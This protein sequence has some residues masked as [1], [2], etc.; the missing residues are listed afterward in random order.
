MTQD[1]TIDDTS[2]K[3]TQGKGTPSYWQTACKQLAEADPVMARLIAAHH[4]DVLQGS[5]DALQTLVNAVVGQQISVHAAESIWKRFQA[6]VPE[7]TPPALAAADSD[8]LRQT[9][10]SYRKVEYVQGIAHAFLDGTLDTILDGH[11][12]NTLDDSQVR[13][14]LC[15]IRGVGPWTADMFLIFYLKRP[16]VLPT[17]DLGLVNAAVRLYGLKESKKSDNAAGCDGA[18]KLSEPDKK[19]SVIRLAEQWRPWRTVATWYIWRDLDAKPV[20]Y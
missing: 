15:S 9:G 14:K 2:R 18:G 8:A 6:L 17:G 4:N 12:L 7:M 5:G 11:H 10:L 1:R 3:P 20:L 13:Q 19:E 16:D